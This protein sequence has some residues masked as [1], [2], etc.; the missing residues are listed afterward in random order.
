MAN[1]VIFL[2]IIGWLGKD[3]WA[4]FSK[5]LILMNKQQFFIK[6]LLFKNFKLTLYYR[7]IKK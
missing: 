4:T 2:V 7:I 5:R 6:F 3:N 1:L